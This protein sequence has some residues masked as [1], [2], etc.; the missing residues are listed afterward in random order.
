MGLDSISAT[1]AYRT[2]DGRPI[3]IQ[4]GNMPPGFVYKTSGTT[5]KR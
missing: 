3:N 5:A 1:L 2:F 4:N